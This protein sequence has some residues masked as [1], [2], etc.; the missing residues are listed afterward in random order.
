MSPSTLDPRTGPRPP[1]LPSSWPGAGRGPGSVSEATPSPHRDLPSL[2]VQ[3]PQLCPAQRPKRRAPSPGQA[4]GELLRS[5]GRMGTGCLPLDPVVARRLVCGCRPTSARGQRVTELSGRAQPVA[6]P[7]CSRAGPGG[8]CAGSCCIA[9]LEPSSRAESC[10]QATR[11]LSWCFRPLHPTP[12]GPR[13]P[14][15]WDPGTSW[16]LISFLRSGPCS[17]S[18]PLGSPRSGSRTPHLR[19]LACRAALPAGAPGR[20]RAGVAGRL[21]SLG[22][23]GRKPRS[24]PFLGIEVAAWGLAVTLGAVALRRASG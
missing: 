19:G 20:C 21:L 12:L 14:R 10:V 5:G 2:A 1:I 9:D 7:V 3:C 17:G 8:R 18:V 22:G 13:L 15:A 23:L 11:G 24:S 4:C 6:G 16:H